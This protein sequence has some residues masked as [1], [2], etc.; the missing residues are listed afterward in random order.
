MKTVCGILILLLCTS[1]VCSDFLGTKTYITSGGKCQGIA[2]MRVGQPLNICY[3]FGTTESQYWTI[4]DK[5]ATRS[6]YTTTDCTGTAS[7]S[8]VDL[9]CTE[10]TYVGSEVVVFTDAEVAKAKAE[11]VSIISYSASNKCVSPSDIYLPEK[12][13]DASW[14]D[15]CVTTSSTSSGIWSWNTKVFYQEIYSTTND[16]TGTA[17]VRFEY[18]L[19]ECINKSSTSS[20]LYSKQAK[21]GVALSASPQSSAFNAIMFVFVAVITLVQ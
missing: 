13:Y 21:K 1:A 4:A 2:Q 5:K 18:N 12:I 15:T 6:T 17:N 3:K 10:G 9:K 16:C 14:K 20:I 7:T 11:G 8:Y 19:N